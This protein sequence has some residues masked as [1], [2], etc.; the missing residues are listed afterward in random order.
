MR[1]VLKTACAVS[2]VI[3]C[4]TSSVAAQRAPA[5][6]LEGTITE[7]PQ[8]RSLRTAF[9]EAVR[10][11][12]EPVESFRAVPDE[13][14]RFHMDSL[15]AGRYMIQLASATLDSMELA[16]PSNE[17]RVIAGET[18]HTDFALPAGLVLRDA[19]CQG[20]HLG[21]GRGVVAGRATNADTEEPLAHARVVVAWNEVG[22]DRATLKSSRR[23][24]TGVVETGPRGEYRLCGVPT[25]SWLSIQLQHANRAGGIAR[26]SVSEQEGAVVRHLSMSLLG[27]A[28]V[29]MLDSVE[30]ISLLID[31]DMVVGDVAP[32]LLLTGTATVTG[33]VRGSK[34]E[35]LAGAEVRVNNARPVATTDASGRFTLGDLPAGTQLLNARRIGFGT[36]ETDVELRAGQRSTRDVTLRTAVALDSV[37]VVGQRVHYRDLEANRRGNF[38]GKFLMA[39]DIERRK[40]TDVSDLILHLGGFLV[41]G[42]GPDATVMSNLAKRQHPSCTT[43]NVVIDGAQWG[44]INFLLPHEVAGIEVYHDGATAPAG[45][46]SDCGVIVIWTKQ[47]HPAPKPPADSTVAP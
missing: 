29:A 10:L 41:A 17:L 16:L 2:G 22:V 39:A 33:V 8:P 36:S 37:R 23:E 46:K 44:N 14:G 5:G 11:D 3:L 47:H 21:S 31:A 32:A 4:A 6:R 9:I 15:P 24:R 20:L 19:L 43:S 28:T 40:P 1:G 45:Y 7:K 13:R 26:V 34:G 25:G 42:S 30:R 18:V 12:A 35:P 27:A 38:F